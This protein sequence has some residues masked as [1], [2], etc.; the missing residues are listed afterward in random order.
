[1]RA[2]AALRLLPLLVA[3][4]VAACAT[5]L[6]DAY[7]R[8]PTSASGSKPA[9]QVAIG[10]NSVGEECTQQAEAGQSADVFC[11]TWQQPSARVR[12]GGP[13][14]ARQ[15]AQFATASQWRTGIDSRLRCD[16]PV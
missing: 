14:T 7:V 13:G 6:P 10:R 9:A 11:G 2:N 12:S 8:T 15:L 4:L 16:P 3:L 5:P 1:M